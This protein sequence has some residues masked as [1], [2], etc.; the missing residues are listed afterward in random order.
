[1]DRVR[2]TSL[3]DGKK[4]TV[5]VRDT[6]RMGASRAVGTHRGWEQAEL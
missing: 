3:R 4:V 1:M 5:T 6:Q 2:T